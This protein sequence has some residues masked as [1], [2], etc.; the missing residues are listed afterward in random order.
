MHSQVGS[1]QHS[2]VKADPGLSSRMQATL[3]ALAPT[4]H[5]VASQAFANDSTTIDL[6]TAQSELIRPE[7]LEF[8]K[9]LVED[10]ITEKTFAVPAGD[11]GDTLTRESLASFFN[12]SFNP[13]HTVK[14]EHIV[15]TAGA[16]DAL[17][18]VIHAICDEGDSI[19]VPGPYWFGFDRIT[20]ARQNVNIVV[21]RPPTYQNFDNYLLPSIQAAYD[22][23]ADK[24]RIKAVLICNPHNPT[25]RCYTRKSLIECMEFC[26]ERGLH[27]ISDEIYALTALNDTPRNSSRF[28]SAL[29]LTEPLVPEGAVKIDPSRVHVIWAASKLFGSSGFRIL[30]ITF[31]TPTDGIFVFARLARHAQSIEDEQDFFHRLALQGVLLGPGNVYK[32]VDKDFG[33]ARI[34]FS[35]PVKVMEVALERITTFLTMEG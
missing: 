10:K 31:V 19:V 24:S 4:P 35:I 20:R 21:A 12:T 29:S 30:H 5:D 7:L 11:G 22:F 9:T 33:W 34:R 16:S 26:Q 13:I 3:R 15:L 2:D 14:P 17:E 32:G 28:V 25:S 27:F 18:S 1:P 6:S 23:A 8:L